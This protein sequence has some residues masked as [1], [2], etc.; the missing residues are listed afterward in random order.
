[1]E[2]FFN[3]LRSRGFERTDE[4]LP[5]DSRR[6]VV[7]GVGGSG[8]T[9]LIEAFAIANEWVR[10]YTLTSHERFDISGRGISQYKGQP[11]DEKLWTILDEYGQTDNPETLPPFNVLATDPYQ[12]FRCQ[13]LRAHFVSLRSYRVPHH[14]AQAITQYTGFPIEAAGT[15]LHE[16]K[17]T[18]GPWTDKLRQQI[19]VEDGEIHYQLSRRQCP[20]KLITDAIGEQWPTVTVVFDRSISPESARPLRCLFYIAAT[21]SSNELN[22][23]TYVPT[24]TPGLIKASLPHTSCRLCCRPRDLPSEN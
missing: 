2:D 10:A 15:D 14:I 22:I 17:Y 18:V 20:H 16:G 7:H 1:M 8:K 9:S 13:P 11:I 5:S 3:C 23:R 19:L 4:P 6:I 21:R 12:A 24:R